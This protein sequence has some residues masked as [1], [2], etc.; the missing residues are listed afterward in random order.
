MKDNPFLALESLYDDPET[1]NIRLQMTRW[2]ESTLTWVDDTLHRHP[3]AWPEP[4]IRM[5]ALLMLDEPLHVLSAPLEPCLNDF[6]NRRIAR[7][8]DE[9]E[10]E[11]VTSGMTLWKFYNHSFVVKTPELTLGFDLHR[12]PFD[13]FSVRPELFDRIVAVTQALFISHEHSDHADADVVDRMLALGRP[14]IVPPG[15]WEGEA[16]FA[17]LIRPARD[18][19]SVHRLAL[20]DSAINYRVFPGHQGSEMLNNVYVVGLPNGVHVM[21]T[22][23]QSNMEDFAVWIDRVHEHVE[24]DVLLP[25]CWST[26]LRRL[27][28]GVSPRLVITGHE[29]E[30]SHPV[31]HR[32]AFSKTYAHIVAEPTP[33]LVMAWGERYHYEPDEVLL[34]ATSPD[35]E[36]GPALQGIK[37]YLA[38]FVA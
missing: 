3:P 26:D 21:Q 30:M 2:M 13:S 34:P 31:D 37:G 18:G 6:L 28:R 20:G 29:N 36:R 19:Q 12:G 11:A 27:I 5:K 23:D 22:G 15:L 16:A 32:E 38:R 4:A 33:V 17:D 14:V 35:Q 7:A 9:I 25:N 1:Q 8:V 10:A 24:V